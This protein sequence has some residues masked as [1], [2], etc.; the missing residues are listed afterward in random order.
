MGAA[1][2][3][4]IAKALERGAPQMKSPPRTEPGLV[5]AV[6]LSAIPDI[7]S[8]WSGHLRSLGLQVKLTGVFCHQ[9]PIVTYQDRKGSGQRCELADLLVVID[10]RTQFWNGRRAVLIQAKMATSARTVRIKKGQDTAQLELYQDWPLFDFE[11]AAYGLKG[12]DLTKGS[13]CHYS[14]AYG[15]IDRHWHSSKAPRWTQH[16]ATP[17]P[18]KT[19]NAPEFGDF[20]ARMVAGAAACGRDASATINPSWSGVV[21]ALLRETLAK[22]FS[23]SPSLGPLTPPRSIS[24]MAFMQASSFAILAGAGGPPDGQ[25]S[26][27]E[28]EP[29]GISTLHLDIGEIDIPD[30]D[31][32]E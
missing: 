21:E 5:A 11:Q 30:A 13:D 31:R 14:G 15:I 9:S 28:G 26:M 29:S 18:T 10:S 8:A 3:A 2:N 6:H 20:L 7:A 22:N 32:A 24:T 12:V 25:M 19:Y 4:A 27:I 16:P 23:H 17:T 1:A